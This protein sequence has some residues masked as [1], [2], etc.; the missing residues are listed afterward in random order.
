ML[1]LKQFFMCSGNDCFLDDSFVKNFKNGIVNHVSYKHLSLEQRPETI[2]IFEL[3]FKNTLPARIIE[4]GTFAGG[5]TLIL[6]DVLDK[7]N[8]ENIIVHTYD[9]SDQSMLKER[10]IANI[11]INTKNLFSPSYQKIL[12]SNAEIEIRDL[13]SQE[14]KTILLCDGG[15]KKCEFNIL[16]Q[17]LKPEDIIMAHDYA[18]NELF[19]REHMINNIWNWME[20]NDSDISQACVT[21]NLIDFMKDEL[22]S[23]AWVGKRKAV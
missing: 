6:R 9:V 23:V 14:G 21:N 11:Q 3:L 15:C 1:D 16:S 10:N 2:D 8:M 17:Y 5:L 20:I 19:F 4:I 12:D 18:P 7:L 13:I 22:L